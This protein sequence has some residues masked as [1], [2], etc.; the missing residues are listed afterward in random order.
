M[1]LGEFPT[2]PVDLINFRQGE[3]MF[4]GR[5]RGDLSPF[6]TSGILAAALLA[7]I[8]LHFALGVSANLKRLSQVNADI[9]AVAAPV[10]GETDPANAKVQLQPGIAKIN[11][12]LNLIPRNLPHS[13][14]HT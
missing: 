6:Y 4:R 1:L 5:V 9:A 10:L 14:P 2:K 11:K 12:R 13:P 3:F 8:I 7:V